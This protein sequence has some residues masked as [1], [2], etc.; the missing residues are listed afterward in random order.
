MKENR[1]QIKGGRAGR[2]AIFDAGMPIL[3]WSKVHPFA[4]KQ[5]LGTSDKWPT[6]CQ[7]G[8]TTSNQ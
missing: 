3:A 5:Q 2:T 4:C 1:E 8:P 6:P 7:Q